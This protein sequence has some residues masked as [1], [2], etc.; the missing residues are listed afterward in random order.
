MQNFILLIIFDFQ[1][2]ATGKGCPLGFKVI[3]T[4]VQFILFLLTYANLFVCYLQRQL[5][6]GSLCPFG[7]TVLAYNY[8]N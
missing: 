8:Y 5:V 7:Y 4:N 6:E 1:G 2:V 3:T